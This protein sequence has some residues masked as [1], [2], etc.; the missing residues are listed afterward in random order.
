MKYRVF[1]TEPANE[2]L[3]NIVAYIAADNV[4]AALKM[5]DKIMD[6]LTGLQDHPNKG[7]YPRNKRL[8]AEGY[9]KLAIDNYIATYRLSEEKNEAY[10][11]RVFHG[12][13]N[14]EKHI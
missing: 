6:V 5:H 2:D 12:A 4:D 8:K 9:R 10:V 13:M 3:K 7:A 14:Y 11:I 1:I